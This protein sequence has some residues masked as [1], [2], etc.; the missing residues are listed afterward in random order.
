M[1]NV[2]YHVRS[3]GMLPSLAL[4]LSAPLRRL[5]PGR[6]FL[7]YEQHIGT[8]LLDAL[9]Y[10]PDRLEVRSA[11]AVL[12]PD[13]H[14]TVIFFRA[15][16]I[17]YKNDF[18]KHIS[19]RLPFLITVEFRSL[20]DDAAELHNDLLGRSPVFINLVFFRGTTWLLKKIFP[21]HQIVSLK[22]QVC[23][24]P[25]KRI[26]SVIH[27]VLCSKQPV[28][29]EIIYPA[30]TRCKQEILRS[31]IE[32]A[33]K[34]APLLE[35]W[36][37]ESVRM[38]HGWPSWNEALRQVHHPLTSKDLTLH[39]PARQRLVF[40]E[41]LAMQLYAE[42]GRIHNACHAPKCPVTPQVEAWCRALPFRLTE[43]QQCAIE[44]IQQDLGAEQPMLRL[45]QGDVGSGK[46]LVALAAAYQVLSAGYQVAFLAPTDVLARQHFEAAR[47]YLGLPSETIV[48]YAGQPKPK[49]RQE[50]LQGVASGTVRLLV[51][52][53]ALIQDCVVFHHLGLAIIDEQHR[54]GVE[55]RLSFYH[56]SQHQKDDKMVSGSLHTLFL[57][58]TP[59]PRTLVLS[60]SGDMSVSILT[61]KPSHQQ[62]IESRVMSIQHVERVLDSL[63]RI[64]E[65]GQQIYWVCPLVK[66]S[67]KLDLMTVEERFK[68]LKRR[69]PGKVSIL[70]GQMKADEKQS[71]MSNFYAE[72]TS[73]L[74]TTTVVEIGVDAPNAT[75][76]VIEN[77]ERFGLAQLHQLR[78]RVGRGRHPSF[79][80][81]LY[82]ENLTKVA[83]KRLE[84]I[85]N[86]A[87]GFKIAEMDLSLRGSG[88][89]FGTQQSGHIGLRLLPKLSGAE[90]EATIY[91][92]LLV[93]AAQ[94]AKVL[95]RQMDTLA[96]QTLLFLFRN[97]VKD[98]Q[99]QLAG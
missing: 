21:L 92:Q 97:D 76:M 5:F 61:E 45:L 41:L 23:Y 82:G 66:A 48:L 89:I 11:P 22:G 49:Q 44:D 2:C 65:K 74:V 72:K 36:I 37:P 25:Q 58:A 20:E 53:H 38:Q 12:T 90:S 28:E 69:F 15:K 10:F 46:T 73:I 9:F 77:A 98:E 86:F 14:K 26:F 27:P 67:E 32:K 70:H 62:P 35:D 88:N 60:Q 93:Q 79:C 31:L 59:I 50:I 33:L 42:K 71:V 3:F 78:G 83:Q 63:Q 6:S 30:G 81:F 57:S 85:R 68:T 84:I 51:G 18:Q 24:S 64:L 95:V 99:I 40:D 19:P 47:R 94:L 80:L 39:N 87:D 29:H 56:K 91:S 16:V 8:T 13:L 34:M 43:S 52:T 75:V 7:P 96:V 4:Q 1:E 54:F 55:Q 17:G